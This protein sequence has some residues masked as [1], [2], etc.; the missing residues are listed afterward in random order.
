MIGWVIISRDLILDLNPS[1]SISAILWLDDNQ[2]SLFFDLLY[3]NTLKYN[4]F[5]AHEKKN[6]F[7]FEL[8]YSK[9]IRFNENY[10]DSYNPL[11]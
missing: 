11:I 8:L 1:R 6:G 10:P 9:Q 5:E 3:S 4:S 7:K 2:L